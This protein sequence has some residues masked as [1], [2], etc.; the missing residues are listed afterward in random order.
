MKRMNIK[1][2]AVPLR[3]LCLLVMVAVIATAMPGYVNAQP[4]ITVISEKG[5]PAQFTSDIERAAVH[6]EAFF[7]ERYG[8]EFEKNIRIIITPDKKA[9]AA[10]RMR[11]GGESREKAER[12]AQK[13]S[14]TSYGSKGVILL[15][16]GHSKM[17]AE[18][19]KRVK[20]TI[21]ELT[22]QIQAQLSNK[23]HSRN[24]YIWLSEG[25]ANALAFRVMERA[26]F[27]TVNEQREEWLE[28]LKESPKLPAVDQ[29]LERA[30]WMPL[31]E[32]NTNPYCAVTIMTEFLIDKC[33]GYDQIIDFYKILKDNDREYAFKKA[34]GF[35]IE[36]FVHDFDA[37][38]QRQTPNIPKVRVK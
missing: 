23:R 18:S 2:Y 38:Y 25:S 3:C 29:L 28:E 16:G 10:A 27:T 5:V 30:N 22:H 31:R 24:G 26:D 21:H 12:H 9:F 7:K 14:G 4:K 17:A 6:A 20:T 1:Q 15:N 36:E 32:A 11:E 34:F 37:Y 33:G 8:L 19:D 35:T 13:A